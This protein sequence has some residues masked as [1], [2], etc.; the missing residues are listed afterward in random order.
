MH[1]TG[2]PKGRSKKF[3][4]CTHTGTRALAS[5]FYLLAQASNTWMQILLTQGSHC[6]IHYYSIL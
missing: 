5:V 3:K 6:T 2:L 4:L 1:N